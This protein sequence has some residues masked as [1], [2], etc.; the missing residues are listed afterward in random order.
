MGVAVDQAGEGDLAR[1]VDHAAR[2]RWIDAPG[3]L[4]SGDS[5]SLNEEVML[6]QDD[7]LSFTV[8]LN[9]GRIPDQ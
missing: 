6:G 5:I 7:G 9:D 2:L 8:D 3:W 1:G 4:Y